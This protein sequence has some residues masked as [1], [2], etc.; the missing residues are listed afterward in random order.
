[1]GPLLAADV[2]VLNGNMRILSNWLV[3]LLR[4]CR[5]RKTLLWGHVE[6]RNRMAAYLRW[7]LLRL[8]HGFICYG[9]RDQEKL[10]TQYPWLKTWVASNACLSISELEEPPGEETERAANAVLFVGRLIAEKKVHLLVEAFLMA[11]VSGGLP[12]DVR[13]LLVG[14]GREEER[15]RR[16]AKDA[17]RESE[18]VFAGHVQSTEALLPWYAQSFCCVSPGYVGLSATQ[19]CCFGVPMIVAEGEFHS[20]EIEVCREGFNASFFP[21]DDRESLARRLG[22]MYREREQWLTRRGE[23]ADWGRTNYTFER[24]AEVFLQAIGEIDE[25]SRERRKR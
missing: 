5:G 16:M 12:D 17:G 22:Q 25:A 15:L 24:M 4:V 6:G 19:A 20:P 14:S 10:R 23:I 8:S 1:L 9:E 3:Q 18:V 7:L 21:K 2:A 13:L 11:R